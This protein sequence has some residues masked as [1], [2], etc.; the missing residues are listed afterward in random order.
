MPP[1]TAIF[2][3]AWIVFFLWTF[4]S[5][6]NAGEIPFP[7][8]ADEYPPPVTVPL[9]FGPP[10]KIIWPD[11]P[12]NLTSV[13]GNFNFN[14]LPV[15]RFDSL[16]FQ[17]FPKPPEE[18]SF[19]WN[20]LPAAD[21]KYDNLPEIPLR[22]KTSVLAAPEITKVA[23]PVL[24]NTKAE[25][26]YDFGDQLNGVAIQALF[27]TKNGFTWIATA[28]GLYRYD[29]ENLFL[30]TINELSSIISAMA[31]DG[32][33]KLWITTR[34]NGLFVLDFKNG[35]SRNLSSNEGLLSNFGVRI[36]IDHENKVWS[37]FLPQVF[38]VGS[39]I[40][41][42]F[43]V[44]ID[45]ARQTL[46][47]LQQA[48]GLSTNS[49]SGI[50]EDKSNNIWI[51]TIN[52][53]A[54][55]LDLKNNRI[56]YLDKAHGLNT[57]T[58]TVVNE[59]R[60]GRM[61]VTGFNGELN[62]IDIKKST[63]K[64]FG[65]QQGFK[66]TFTARIIQDYLGNT[67]IG[68]DKG[69]KIIDTGLQLVKSIDQTTGLNADA[70]T[71]LL[72]DARHQ[73][74]IGNIRGLNIFSKND[75]TI[76]RA[77]N[78]QISTLLA[79][80]HGR[81]WIGTLDKGIQILDT[82][83]GLIKLYNHEN[84]L[85]DDFIQYI[86]EYNG[87]I[88]LSTQKGGIEIIDT[89]LKKIERIGA[90]QGLTTGNITAI[91]KDK[92]N[93]IWLGGVSN[94]VDVLDLENK[95]IRHIGSAEGLNDSTIIDIKRDTKGLM[96]FYSQKNGVGVMDIDAKTVQ[97]IVTSNFKSLTGAVEDNLLML[98]QEGKVWLTTSTSGLFII[99]AARDSVTHFTTS[100]GLLSNTIT[101]LKEYNGKIYAGTNNG[102]NILT[103]PS[104]TAD[105]KWKIESLGKS[106]GIIKAVRSY[107]S[108]LLLNNGQYWWG[109]D[110]IT[111]I[112][113]LD[114]HFKETLA[115]ATYITGIEI[116][117]HRQYFVTNPWENVNQK[118]TIWNSNEKNNTFYTGG[119]PTSQIS[120]LNKEGMQWDSLTPLYHLPLNLHLPYNKNYLQF[121]FAQVHLGGQ[122]TV[123]YRYIFE[124]IDQKWSE[125]TYKES[126]ENYP[127]IPP[128]N[129]TFKVSSLYRGKWSAPVAWSFTITPPWWKTWWAYIVYTL[130]AIGILRAYIVYRSRRLQRENKILEEKV[131][132]RT[133]QLQQSLE[134]LKSTQAQL[135]QSE[136][137]AS[138]GELTAGIA[139]EIQNPLNFINNFSEVNTEL[140]AEM[141]DEIDKGNMEEV[142][143][144]AADI[145]ANEQKINHHG[146]RADGIVKGMLQHSRTGSRQKE[147]TNINTLA[148]EYLR[149]A[150]HGL[151]A[152]DKSFNAI[153]KTDFDET[154][155][156]INI[157][158]QDIGRVILNL[159]TNAF[160]SVTEKKKHLA[161]ADLPGEAYEPTV[162]V[163]TKKRNGHVEIQV[164]DNGN[165]VPQKVLDKIFQ[166]FFTTKPTG[167][168]TGLGLSLSYDIIKAHNG[169]L[170][171]ETK[172]GEGAMFII[173]LPE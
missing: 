20:K 37:T 79:D 100:Q 43:V 165:G 154:M 112:S 85:S 59:D 143:S 69:V 149:L 83:T 129:Y 78:T 127:N 140:I 108:D 173:I 17:P 54:N 123:W 42:G 156:N 64:K 159:I 124:G 111:I 142:K 86:V 107:N 62:V 132:L 58:L 14:K 30:Y 47:F 101:Y 53:G 91:E 4:T 158:P 103:P 134:E 84:G 121:H 170:K 95:K 72:E 15:I 36:M 27:K 118:D 135:I 34:R 115:P 160:Y 136:K 74:F 167:E 164:K 137:M 63:I 153:M 16:G 119:K 122:D 110:G 8:T 5:C 155:G 96:W 33:E 169:E 39:D 9:Q 29:G 31:E 66:R 146:K 2:K 21:F 161:G 94:G 40:S 60:L 68:G 117:N 97:H 51:T 24:K 133:K 126:S 73:V 75:L 77:G 48:Q 52:A 104:L 57:D 166:P 38:N 89:S 13:Q 102:L 150:Y 114:E 131:A 120:L 168:G 35:I 45:Q 172:E 151:R 22:F 44:I 128:G 6:K 46:K 50:L 19:D 7:G 87:S 11:K 116:F 145:A 93:N 106:A 138:L 65:E 92:E 55:I 28:K 12:A 56:K 98:D 163:S 26:I 67:W 61:W 171:V 157:I 41:G 152:K 3:I 25:I 139:H 144:I 76:R 1:R 99:N 90:A 71:Q 148:D 82:A 141:K 80:S 23:R 32:D 125:K 88:L 49:P 113:N 130:A 109:D 81:I 10:Q 18:A 147:P 162:S 105:K 70:G